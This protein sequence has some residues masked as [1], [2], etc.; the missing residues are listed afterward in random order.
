[1]AI[2]SV[3]T[4]NWFEG[5]ELERIGC[6]VR[7]MFFISTLGVKAMFKKI[8]TTMKRFQYAPRAREFVL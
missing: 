5:S 1:L 3:S 7:G 2:S 6:E 4:V 8:L